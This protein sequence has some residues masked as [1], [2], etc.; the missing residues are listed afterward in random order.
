MSIAFVSY[1][2]PF[3][4]A[5]GIAAVMGRLPLALKDVCHTE[6]IVVTPFHHRIPQTAELKTSL[7]LLAEFA[8]NF[9]SQQIHI[10]ALGGPNGHVF[11]RTDDERF[12]AGYPHPYSVPDNRILRRDALLF[13]VATH[14]VL[15]LLDPEADWVLLLQDWQ[16]A[17][18]ALAAP[19]T[20]PKPRMILT[21]HNGYDEE[22]TDADLADFG[23]NPASCPGYTALTRAIPLVEPEIVTVSEQ[24]ALEILDDP[25]QSRVLADHLQAPLSGRLVGINNGPFTSLHIPSK[26]FEP[27]LRGDFAA[28]ARWKQK[29]RSIVLQELGRFQPSPERP[30]WGDRGRVLERAASGIPWFVMAGRDDS[31]QKGYDVAA[32]AAR[33][34]LRGDGQACFFF[35]PIPGDEGL[36]G[37]SF[38]A[39]LAEGFPDS[40]AVLPFRWSE[41]F[42]ATLRGASFG[43]MPSFYEPFGMANEFYLNGTLGIGRATGGIVQQ[44]VPLK[45]C[46]SFSLAAEK[47]TNRWHAWSSPPTGLLYRETLSPEDAVEGWR[48]INEANYD[49]D[50]SGVRRLKGRKP[51]RLFQRMAAELELALWDAC[52]IAGDQ[53]T[54]CRMLVDGVR[55]ITNTFSWRRAAAE[56]TRITHST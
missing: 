29:N 43:L 35:F 38:L 7:S 25:L 39:D 46:A 53:S 54:Y 3:A 14:R 1:E 17:T 32:E 16:A 20:V 45:G 41:V 30:C 5:G 56:Y 52:A 51:I 42:S 48:Q 27:A 33:S 18:T 19:P 44:I 12:F 2:T 24:F 15:A 8:V 31:R 50:E 47:I 40:V 28:L 49:C 9:Q 22:V 37:I 13:G 10:E 6:A 23:I 36:A 26:V 21:L 55:H 34:F 11:L 4:P